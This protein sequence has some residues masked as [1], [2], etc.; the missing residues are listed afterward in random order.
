MGMTSRIAIGM[1]DPYQYGVVP[2]GRGYSKL[3]QWLLTHVCQDTM[4]S[5]SIQLITVGD[6]TVTV[7]EREDCL[8][9]N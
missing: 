4:H 6:T 2:T 3:S 7:G 8:T 9:R 1:H 5:D